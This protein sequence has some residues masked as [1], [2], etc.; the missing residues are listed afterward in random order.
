[1]LQKDEI[2]G[3]QRD[4]RHG[5]RPAKIGK[6]RIGSDDLSQQ[7]RRMSGIKK[8][9][10]AWTK[11]EHIPWPQGFQ[12]FLRVF[13]AKLPGLEDG[14]GNGSRTGSHHSPNREVVFP[15]RR[16]K[17]EMA[18]SPDHP[19]RQ[20]QHKS[21]PYLFGE[22]G[23]RLEAA[24]RISG[25]PVCRLPWRLARRLKRCHGD[26]L[27]QTGSPGDPGQK[28]ASFTR[29]DAPM[30][31]G[32]LDK[33]W[34]LHPFTPIAEWETGTPMI[35]AGGE[36]ARIF[37]DRGNAYL[38]G[39]SSLWVN[40]LGHRHPAID[41]AI[42][43]Q[44]EKI[45]HTTFLGL[46]HEGGIRLAED[47]ARLAPGNLKRVFYSD[48]GSTSVE[49]AL[50]LAFL[51][52]RKT[53]PGARRFFS[54][55]RAYHGDTLGAVGIGGIDRFHAPFYPL[56]QESLKAPAPDCF[57]CPLG[58]SRD[59]CSV[60]C[61]DVAVRTVREH[62][63]ELAAVILEPRLQAAGGM[64]VWPEGY[65]TRIAQA[66]REE[67]IPLILDEVATGFGRTGALFACQLEKVVPDFL[68][69]GKGLTG[70]YLPLAITLF[71]EET[72][73]RLR[74]DPGIFYHGHSYTAN[75]LAVAAAR[76]TL[77]TLEE[78]C[79]IS[80][81]GGKR[82]VFEV[83]ERNLANLPFVGNIR[84]IGLVFALDVF[85]D[86]SRKIP[87]SRET[88]TGIERKAQ[89]LGLIVRPLTNTLYLIPPLSIGVDDLTLMGDILAESL[90]EFGK[91]G[92]PNPVR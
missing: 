55:E 4:R 41:R 40:L 84:S 7:I 17:T 39:T 62:A 74:E 79:H 77:G 76:A 3:F 43:E 5:Q 44:L 46:T 28:T 32:S 64:I 21:F 9:S 81:I 30:D 42:R 48:N 35:I 71:S 20:D 88:M 75:P 72:Y 86:G 23:I 19:S 18:R 45:A 73:R 22:N 14:S 38:D 91:A 34:I 10:H 70:G 92:S 16:Q 59:R 6:R 15:A 33:Q 78:G 65:L 87:A 8:P 66:A 61:A 83:L 51:L 63:P 11:P 69:A 80:A 50:K 82:T 26:R 27:M 29:S 67:E 90:R 52:R 49:I 24:N 12:S 31:L 37:D 13:Y 53:H 2:P 60:D 36:G 85:A 68:C 89:S 57:S 56:S 54:L 47:L 1:M 58:L 25:P